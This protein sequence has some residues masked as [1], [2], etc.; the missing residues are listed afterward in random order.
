M[1]QAPWH[2]FNVTPFGLAHLCRRFDVERVEQFGSFVDQWEWIAS[3]AGAS[4]VLTAGER[5]AMRAVCSKLEAAMTPELRW[6]TA[7][8]V[9]IVG[10]KP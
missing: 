5:R 7:S 4:T 8:G 3:E 1:H 6:N 9:R 10:R 2:F